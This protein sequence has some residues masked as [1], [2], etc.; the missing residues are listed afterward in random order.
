MSFFKDLAPVDGVQEAKDTLG[1]GYQ[2]LPSG[3]Y[4]ATIKAAYAGEAKSG[5]K[6]ISFIFDVDGQEINETMYITSGTAKGGKTYYVA[7]DGTKHYLP[8]FL[9]AQSIGLLSAGKDIHQLTAEDKIIELYDWDSKGKVKTKV[10]MFT[11]LLGKPVKLGLLHRREFKRVKNDAGEYVNGTD[12][13][14]FNTVDKVFRAKDDMTVAEI[15]AKADEATFIK[16]WTNKWEGNVDDKTGGATPAKSQSQ[17][18]PLEN[19]PFA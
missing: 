5:A 18:T 4:N 16:D 10:K 8:S 14:D 19:D 13:R 12:T 9:T 6:S 17:A 7:K 15:R 1:G 3:V 11:D 2:V